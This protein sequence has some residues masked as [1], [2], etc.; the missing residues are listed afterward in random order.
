MEE[1]LTVCRCFRI[2]ALV[3]LLHKQPD[4]SGEHGG[5]GGK[6]ERRTL[7]LAHFEKG[8]GDIVVNVARFVEFHQRKGHD[9]T[10]D[11]PLPAPDNPIHPSRNLPQESRLT[12]CLRQGYDGHIRV[13]VPFPAGPAQ[14]TTGHIA[15]RRVCPP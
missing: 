6:D 2:S 14:V 9:K 5:E 1:S 4:E 12:S 11:R 7:G 13:R 8:F 10:D 3:P 15:L